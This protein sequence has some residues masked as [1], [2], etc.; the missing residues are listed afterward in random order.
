MPELP[1]SRPQAKFLKAFAEG[2]FHGADMVIGADQVV[3]NIQAQF[4]L[5]GGTKVQEL[6]ISITATSAVLGG[7]PFRWSPVSWR[8]RR[9]AKLMQNTSVNIFQDM[10]RLRGLI[11]A[12]YYGHWVGA[13]ED[14]NV[15]NPVLRQIGFTLPK[16][17]VRGPGEVPIR[18]VEGREIDR[19]HILEGSD[20]PDEVDVIV[21]GSGSGGAVAAWNLARQGHNVLVIE[22]GP[23]YPSPR[24]TPE[25]RRMTARLFKHGALQ[26]SK[27]NDFVVFQ[28]RCV[29]GSSVINNGICLRLNQ[30]GHTHPQAPDVLNDWAALGATIDRAAFDAA[31]DAVH[32]KLRISPIEE[33]SARRNGPHLLRGWDA[34]KASSSDPMVQAATQGWFDK[35]YGPSG[36]PDACAYCG[37][38]NT[39]CPYGRKLGMA[40]T[41]LPDACTNHGARIV[42]DAKVERI[43]WADDEAAVRRATGVSIVD[44]D[45][46]GRTIRARKG[47][48]VA[49]GTIAS[50]KLLDRSGIEGA[51]YGISLNI[52]SP[53]IALMPEANASPAWDEDQMATFVDVGDFL[54][55]S[56]F[57]PP[58]SMSTMM[59]G[60]FGEHA[61]R[62]RNY[63]RVASA[64]IL[65]PAD[66]RGHLSGDKLDFKLDAEEDLPVLRRALATLAKVHFAAGAEEVY[67]ALLRG[68]TLRRG[69]DIDAFFAAA[70]READDVTLSSSHPHGG[71]AINADPALGVVDTECRVHATHNVLVT[72]ASVFPSCI[73]VNAQ[74]ATMAMAQYATGRGDPF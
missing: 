68:Q 42:A 65:F 54:L 47:V 26:T 39:G 50:S 71:N 15:D 40:Q 34:Y 32:A 70:V 35:N 19:D 41:Y 24:I 13:S 45:G 28:G 25:E 4:A 31:F 73:R 62:M 72:D 66:R 38:C 7:V 20:I 8:A 52:A 30:P 51:G 48:V 14:D 23:H 60:W 49:C 69:E 1:F 33:R 74:F 16:H 12:G 2:L 36:T 55:E 61:R 58:M 63:G 59:P 46:Q 22:A 21:A 67:P 29:G 9:I 11:Y 57:Q 6:R 56:H 43:L 27:N 3:D 5:V 53:M 18:P 37:Y 64:G 44:A 10:A 17:R